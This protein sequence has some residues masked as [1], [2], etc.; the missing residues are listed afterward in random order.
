ML[1]SFLYSCTHA[2]Y[3]LFPVIRHALSH[4]YYYFFLFC[5]FFSF[6]NI[7][8]HLCA[9]SQILAHRYHRKLI[10]RL[11]RGHISH[12]WTFL[13]AGF[14][15]ASFGQEGNSLCC[16]RRASRS[17][18]PL[19]IRAKSVRHT[20]D[21]HQ[22]KTRHPNRQGPSKPT[23]LGVHAPSSGVY[24]NL[25]YVCAKPFRASQCAPQNRR[26]SSK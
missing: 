5:F 2:A 12:A 16:R 3:N 22:P 24:G 20:S 15:L 4:L 19:A 8:A 1:D 7:Q 10:S 11:Q 9:R 26:R 6:R 17:R 25:P 21:Y 13:F 14:C 18:S 23:H